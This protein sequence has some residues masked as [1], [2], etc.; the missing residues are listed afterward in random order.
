MKTL[1]HVLAAGMTTLVAS[2]AVAEE[3]P[4]R[5]VTVINQTAAG[6][7]PDVICR[8]VTERL[9]RLWGQQVNVVNRQGAAGLLAAQ[10][11]AAAPADG[12]TLYM[13]TSTAL[14]ILPV[15]HSDGIRIDR[16]FVPVTLVGETP[17]VIA[18]GKEVGIGTLGELITAAKN[19]PGAILYA[20][21]AR[22]SV[23]H[24]AGELLR[25]RAGI[26]LTFV[27]YAGAPAAMTDVLGGRVQVIIES[28]SALAGPLRDGSIRALAVTGKDRLAE[29]PG[30]P[31][32]AETLPG[33]AITG[34]FALLA[35]AGTPENVL[36]KIERDLATILSEQ[37]VHQRFATLGVLARSTTPAA[38][39]RFIRQEQE[40]WK[41][42]VEAAQLRAK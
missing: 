20:A 19:R 14:V 30:L 31:T 33:Y 27:P 34:W 23:P 32:A 1:A 13:P 22:G 26:D 6:S 18:V 7:G 2:I 28:L 36:R 11:A 24:L 40:I 10:A 39:T 9:S 15:L 3:Y 35:R 21:N 12:Y 5:H 25:A 42:I 17:M 37:E 16:D 29:H 38:T 4:A 41:P 8:I